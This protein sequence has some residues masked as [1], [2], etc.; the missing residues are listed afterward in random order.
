MNNIELQNL[1]HIANRDHLL[2]YLMNSEKKFV[3]LALVLIDEI[4]SIKV[5][6]RK[7]IKEKSKIY[8]NIMFLYYPLKKEDFGKIWELLPNDVDSYPRI[9]HLYDVDKMLGEVWNLKDKS[10]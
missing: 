9:Y 6:I 3:V 4:E 10:K 5:M 8:K 2:S 1:W 7:H